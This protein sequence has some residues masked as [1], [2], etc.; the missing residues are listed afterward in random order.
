MEIS[1][2]IYNRRRMNIS[3]INFFRPEI[4]EQGEFERELE[5]NL[6]VQEDL[7]ASGKWRPAFDQQIFKKYQETFGGKPIECFDPNGFLAEMGLPESLTAG[8]SYIEMLRAFHV[9]KDYIPDPRYFPFPK[10]M[11]AF[12]QKILLSVSIVSPHLIKAVDS[13]A[14]FL[15]VKKIE[16]RYLTDRD[17]QNR[18]GRAE[19]IVKGDPSDLSKEARYY[20]ILRKRLP[21]YAWGRGAHTGSIDPGREGTENFGTYDIALKLGFTETQAR[22]IAIKCYDVDLSKTHYHD[23]NNKTKPRVTST[24]GE[25]GDIHRHYNRSP[26]GEED[27]R[28]T[29]AKVHLDR[30]FKLI[31][32]GY[33]DTAEQELA[34]G[35]HS[36]QDVFSHAQLTPTI[37][38]IL[39]EFPDFVKYHP[40]AMYETAVVTENYLKKFIKGLNLKMFDNSTELKTR[41]EPSNRLVIG[42][43][44]PEEQSDV[45]KKVDEFPQGLATFLKDN[46]ICIFV[47]A[48][49][50]K[51][52]DHGFGIDLD[53]DGRITPGKWVDINRDGKKQWFEVE[54]QFDNGQEWNQQL[55]AYN[56]QNRMIFISARVL[57]DPKFEAVLKHEINHAIDFTYQDHPQLNVKWEA[58]INKLYN[59]ARRQGEVAFGELD[60]HKYFARIE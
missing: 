10:K 55:A 8:R 16:K 57:K 21:Q 58:Y 39:G 32:E 42:D 44:N 33:Y 24:E 12:A 31:N 52:T 23:P 54:D 9:V 19:E 46:G 40:L 38:A 28:I 56:H 14:D 34:I 59:F 29:A 18:Y 11:A 36:L 41:I 43:A 30:S 37:H 60:P 1:A 27:T 49:G 4:W 48:E 13:V 45:A 17:D 25:I 47:G 5:R 53:G 22:R 35:L 2:A 15:V 50:T 51:L 6:A 7:Y 3:K 26:A 20:G